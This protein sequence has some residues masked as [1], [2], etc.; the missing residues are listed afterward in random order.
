MERG[1]ARRKGRTPYWKF[2]AGTVFSLSSISRKKVNLPPEDNF[3]ISASSGQNMRV[4]GLKPG[5]VVTEHLI[6][7]PPIDKG[8]LRPD[9]SRD[10][11]MLCVL[12]KNKGR[13]GWLSGS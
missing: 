1:S 2:R 7:K 6:L 13:V 10:L 8:Y 11:A 9:P 5:L 3:R 12:E 4:I